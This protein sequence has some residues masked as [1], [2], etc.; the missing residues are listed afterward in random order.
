MW[1]PNYSKKAETK[2]VVKSIRG[3]SL[4]T[5]N[6]EDDGE[7]R[8]EASKQNTKKKNVL[9]VK[10]LD[11]D[12][13]IEDGQV[14]YHDYEDDTEQDIGEIDADIFS[15]NDLSEA[16]LRRLQNIRSR[17]EEIDNQNFGKRNSGNI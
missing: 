9:T 16:E 10:D 5:S 6:D 1:K 17:N 4:E 13:D 11:S 15:P 8:G 3:S 7:Q 2:L 14:S 12:S